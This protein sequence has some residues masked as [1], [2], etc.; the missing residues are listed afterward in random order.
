MTPRRRPTGRATS[1]DY[2]T[3]A[4]LRYHIRLFLRRREIAAR[5]AGIEP[6]QYLLLLQAKGLQARRP[7][8]LG[9][10]AER[11]QLAHHSTVG[12]VDR[13]ARRGMVA[14]RIDESDRRNVLVD[15]RPKG[16]AVLKRL[17]L[18]SLSELR[19]EAP[20]LVAAIRRL[21]RKRGHFKQ[22]ETS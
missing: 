5:E 1:L 4:E 11:L 17:V 9:A 12:L 6:Q 16:E 10:L 22:E 15:L 21:T 2:W 20:A 13:L 8:T 18:H 14:R 7:V 3:L 19:T